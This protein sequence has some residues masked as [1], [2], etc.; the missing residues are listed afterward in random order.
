MFASPLG[1]P[2]R[3]MAA[4]QKCRLQRIAGVEMVRSARGRSVTM[5]AED[6][7]PSAA[8]RKSSLIAPQESQSPEDSG[9]IFAE[10]LSIST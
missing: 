10:C 2:H 9:G 8:L 4:E 3:H 7:N 6:E 5:R 1:V